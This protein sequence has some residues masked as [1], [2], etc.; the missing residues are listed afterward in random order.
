MISLPDKLLQDLLSL[1]G[2]LFG[3]GAIAQWVANRKNKDDDKQQFINQLQEEV[4]EYRKETAELKKNFA[5]FQEKYMSLREEKLH[6]DWELKKAN[7]ETVVLEKEKSK[8]LDRIDHL[9][10]RVAELEKGEKNNGI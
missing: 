6:T 3:G 5:E 8:L 2:I 9:E 7:A 1:V 10:S 4:S